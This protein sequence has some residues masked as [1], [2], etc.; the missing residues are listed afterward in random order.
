MG[1]GMDKDMIM[2]MKEGSFDRVV[3]TIGGLV[4]V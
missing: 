3:G 4:R 1:V 2:K